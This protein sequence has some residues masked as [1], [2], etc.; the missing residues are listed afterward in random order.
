MTDSDQV[1]RDELIE[2]WWADLTAALGVADPGVAAHD[3]LDLAAVAAHEVLRP[4]APLTTFLVGYAAGL[5]GGGS[6]AVTTAREQAEALARAHG[7][8]DEGREA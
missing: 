2:R 8:S 6:E 3:V 7:E 5:A 4:A 1:A